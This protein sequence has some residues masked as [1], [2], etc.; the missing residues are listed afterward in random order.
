MPN[1]ATSLS[2]EA[3]AFLEGF[4]QVFASIEHLPIPEQRAAIKK[5]FHIP[6]DHLMNILKVEDKTIVGR[7]GEIPL[8]I[9]TPK[10]GSDLPVIVNLLRG[11][12]VFGSVDEA[13]TVC[14]QLSNTTGA[15]VISVE[16]R[17]APEHT[18]PIPLEDCYDATL[19]ASKNASSFSGN[20]DKVIICGESAG[21][22]LAAAVA[23]MNRDQN[24]ISLAGQLLLYPVLTTGLNPE[25]Y[26]MSPDKH[27]LSFEN[28][29]FFLNAY[30][31]NPQD[32]ENPYA[33]P[34]KS[35]DLSNLPTILI[36]TAEHDALKHE[37][38][39]YFEALKEAGVSAEHSCYLDVIHGFIDLP[40]AKA[41]RN[42][43]LQEIKAWVNI[44]S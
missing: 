42:E 11:G 39:A 15:I 22:N 32:K 17:L 31:K 3:T 13:E 8:R 14:R 4:S 26:E 36:I 40:I 29:A 43:A 28:M 10:I 7:N 34:L 2:L 25:C 12:F 9:Y 38:E 37:G 33:A 23:L 1:T 30:L 35:K 6:Q 19:W 16:Y 41:T 20:P 5:I 24:Q 21:G 18:F 27:L 44:T